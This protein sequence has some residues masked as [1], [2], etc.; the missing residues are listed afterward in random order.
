MWIPHS[1]DIL[2]KAESVKY[3][4][5]PFYIYKFIFTFYI[6]IRSSNWKMSPLRLIREP[7]KVEK[8]KCG[9]FHTFFTWGGGS[10]VISTLFILGLEWPNSSRNAK[11]I[12]SIFRGGVP[13]SE[14]NLWKFSKYFDFFQGKKIIFSKVVPYDARSLKKKDGQFPH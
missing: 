8:K 14:Q 6:I 11:K 12:F 7:V 9:N 2:K 3:K 4:S 13:S 10:E 5:R 1:T